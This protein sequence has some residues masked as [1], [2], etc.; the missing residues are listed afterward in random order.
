MTVCVLITVPG[1]AGAGSDRS[2]TGTVNTFMT[3]WGRN[4]KARRANL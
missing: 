4:E 2:S 3:E 1:Q